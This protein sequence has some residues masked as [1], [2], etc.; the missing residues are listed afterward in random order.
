MESPLGLKYDSTTK[1]APSKMDM[2][3]MDAAKAGTGQEHGSA[4]QD[5]FA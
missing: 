2:S 1:D 4:Y 3:K 5:C